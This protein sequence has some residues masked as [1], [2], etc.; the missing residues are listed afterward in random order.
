M[1][2]PKFA[3]L[4]GHCGLFMGRSDTFED[5]FEGRVSPETLSDYLR[6]MEPHFAMRARYVPIL[7]RN[8]EEERESIRKWFLEGPTMTY[9]SCWY[10]G[11][12]ECDG[13]WKVYGES[14]ESVAIRST[15]G[16]LMEA[17]PADILL[18]PVQY[19]EASAVQFPADHR[20][21]QF[22]FKRPEYAYESE[23][24]CVR[25]D[26]SESRPPDG[27][28]VTIDLPFLVERV[29]ISPRAPMWFKAT[30]EKVVASFGL[31]IEVRQSSMAVR[32][33]QS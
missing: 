28:L 1:S 10:A 15:V 3:A 5:V 8:P 9:L 30:V 21:W 4:L 23:L 32:P 17:L 25:F 14:R 22:A 16:R 20:L 26:F 12:S 31:S 7:P 11:S 2:F 19:R 33:R 13:M 6:L 27:H 29:V 18:V 24:R